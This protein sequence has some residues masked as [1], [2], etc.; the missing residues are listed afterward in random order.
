MRGLTEGGNVG[1]SALR[2]APHLKNRYRRASKI[3]L[4]RTRDHSTPLDSET[5]S[6]APSRI[7]SQLR[8]A[9]CSERDEGCGGEHHNDE[10]TRCHFRWVNK[11]FFAGLRE[12]R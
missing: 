7:A 9:S 12:A 5:M 1:A 4:V 3:R 2:R 8:D 6:Q 10:R 11:L